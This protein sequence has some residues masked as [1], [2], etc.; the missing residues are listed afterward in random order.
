MV[1]TERVRGRLIVP[2]ALRTCAFHARP[3]ERSNP[4]MSSLST[5]GLEHLVHWGMLYSI[6]VLLQFLVYR[7]RST[8]SL[9]PSTFVNSFTNRINPRQP[10]STSVKFDIS[11]QSQST[12]INLGCSFP[13]AVA[14]FTGRKAFKERNPTLYIEATAAHMSDIIILTWIYMEW[15]RRRNAASAAQTNAFT[16]LHERGVMSTD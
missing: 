9:I 3:D 16:S 14:R 15:E 2:P 5:C 12:S 13:D 8:L 1:V 7:L 11:R 6:E 10:S 4:P